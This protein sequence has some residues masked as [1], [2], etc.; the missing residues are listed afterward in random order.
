MATLMNSN[1][2]MRSA[3]RQIAARRPARISVVRTKAALDPTL[4]VSAST[5]AFLS[6]GRFV[7]LPYQRRE[8]DLEIKLGPKTTGTTF[9]DDLQKP[10]SFVLT[11]KDPSGFNLID[12][13]GWGALGH[14]FAF[15]I[16]ATSSLH[17]AGV[18]PWP[19]V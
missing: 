14:A 7:F 6:V 15:F 19:N 12:V 9:F 4:I 13:F 2:S 5:A 1:I 16:L 17:D 11:S 18:N 3:S 10:A 8:A